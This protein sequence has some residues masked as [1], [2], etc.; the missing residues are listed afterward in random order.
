M[1]HCF[2]LFQVK[3]AISNTFLIVDY[4]KRKDKGSSYLT[5]EIPIV[6]LEE[7]WGHGAIVGSLPLNS[8]H[9]VGII[10]Q[11]TFGLLLLYDLDTAYGPIDQ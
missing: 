3:C 10:K 8:N 9:M 2:F 6:S 7:M 11:I 4:H 5:I 1:M